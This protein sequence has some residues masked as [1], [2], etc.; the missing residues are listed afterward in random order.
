MTRPPRV[1]ILGRP[2]VGKSTLFNALIGRRRAITFSDPGVTR[3]A[4]EVEC[5]LG[6]VRIVLVDTGGYSGNAEGTLDKV[7][8]TRSLG[9]ARAAALVLLVL[10]ATETTTEDDDFIR[11]LRPFSDKILLVVNKVDTPDRDSLVWNA[12]EHGF[13][14]VIGV[15]AA[16]HR[17]IERLKETAAALLETQLE[18]P[19]PR[20]EEP[21]PESR[22]ARR[23]PA[24]SSTK[25][26][27]SAS[28]SWAN[29]IRGN[30]VLPTDLRG[31]T[32]PSFPRL[33]NDAGRGGGRLHVQGLHASGSW[34]RRGS[35]GKAGCRI[36]WSTIP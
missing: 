1:V 23:R 4:V 6:G 11:R 8:A 29:P 21:A 17:S 26:G 16:H 32:A 33:R 18:E 10:D 24:E 7:V 5:V 3:D 25:H 30:P 27:W 34:T 2:N 13:P 15:S 35:G 9:A 19:L 31:R 20:E 36:P 22:R 12:H 28:P 14:N